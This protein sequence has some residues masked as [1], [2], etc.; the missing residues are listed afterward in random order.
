MTE[1]ELSMVC[2]CILMVHDE[3]AY[4]LKVD[5]GVHDESPLRASEKG[6]R[7]MMV[8]VVEDSEGPPLGGEEKRSK[9][10]GIGGPVS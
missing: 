5:A 9:A 6:L 10:L 2:V 4:V 1:V 8:V 7:L 3:N